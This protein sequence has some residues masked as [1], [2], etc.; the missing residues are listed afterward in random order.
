MIYIS[1][2]WSDS[3]DYGRDDS[4]PCLP[5]YF[6]WELDKL[7]ATW[8]AYRV[9]EAKSLSELSLNLLSTCSIVFTFTGCGI[10]QE[11]IR[12]HKELNVF[13]KYVV[14]LDKMSPSALLLTAFVIVLK[15][16]WQAR[17]FNP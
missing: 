3:I 7:N 9:P 8:L 14:L 1:F 10:E 2:F 15:R 4:Q 12:S 17:S 11:F 5:Y 13:I 6:C 16:S